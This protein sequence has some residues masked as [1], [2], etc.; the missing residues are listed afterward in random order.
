MREGSEWTLAGMAGDKSLMRSYLAYAAARQ[1]MPTAPE[2][3]FCELLVHGGGKY[4][5]HGVYLLSESLMA[6]LSRD[7]PAEY[8]LRRERGGASRRAL[9]SRAEREGLAS[10]GWNLAYYSGYMPY[11]DALS[12]IRN[13]IDRAEKILYSDDA[14]EFLSYEDYIDVDSFVDY[15]ILNEFFMNYGSGAEGYIYKNGDGMICAGPVWDFDTA[16]DNEITG[17][18][19]A[20]EWMMS[21]VPWYDRLLKNTEFVRKL[22]NRYGEIS[23]SALAIDG[24]ENLVRETALRLGP[25]VERDRARWA[26]L[27]T[28]A[29]YALLDSPDAADEGRMDFSA[30]AGGGA[31]LMKRQTSGH[32]QELIR[33]RYLLRTHAVMMRGTLRKFAGDKAEMIDSSDAHTKNSL[34]AVVFVA[35]FFYM[36]TLTRR[37]VR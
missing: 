12:G 22:M 29:E 8:V 26:S 5:Y 15:F 31:T 14:E 33:I 3:D 37:S 13:D 4:R 11:D 2:A 27:Y 19:P 9:M 24:I 7:G 6:C 32:D 35:I 10:G 23:R 18:W 30:Y 16:I 34:A 20:G 17:Q 1:F 28:G 36:V 21:K 25:A